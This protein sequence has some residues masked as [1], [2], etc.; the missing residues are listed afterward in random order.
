MNSMFSIVLARPSRG[1]HQCQL[2]MQ[3]L[4]PRW[5]THFPLFMEGVQANKQHSVKTYLYWSIEDAQCMICGSVATI[6]RHLGIV[7]NALVKLGDRPKSMFWTKTFSNICN[8]V[9][10]ERSGILF[11]F[12]KLQCVMIENQQRLVYVVNCQFLRF[13]DKF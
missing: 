10:I 4:N 12:S 6:K 2:W 3:K 8:K 7:C 1:C 11:Q 9:K 5:D 13:P